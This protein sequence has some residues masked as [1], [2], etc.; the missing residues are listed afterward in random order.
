MN[1]LITAGNTQAPIDQVRCITNIF[2]GKTGAGLALEAHRRGHRIT[3]LTSR[4]ESVLELAAAPPAER[5]RLVAYRTFDELRELLQRE[6]SAAPD[7]L[8]HSAAVSDYLCT[9]VYSGGPGGF[10]ASDALRQGKIKSSHPQ[11]WLLLTPAPKL[12]DMVRSLWGFTGLLVKFK[13]EVGVE[14]AQLRDIAEASRLQSQADLMVANTLEGMH[15]WA[16]VGA[17]TYQRIDRPALART[18]IDLLELH[19]ASRPGGAP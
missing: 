18:L 10:P 1:F 9:G 13:L 14:E 3:L 19:G 6:V 4:P 15:E 11:L 2:S 7:I 16:I 12:I 8:I 17:R 5:W